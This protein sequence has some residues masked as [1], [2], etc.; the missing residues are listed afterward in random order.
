[1]TSFGRFYHCK[2]VDFGHVLSNELR[3]SAILFADNL[4]TLQIQILILILILILIRP[5]AFLLVYNY[6][7]P[8]CNVQ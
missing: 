5:S 2:W 8:F 3:V 4:I 1:M 7:R 6:F